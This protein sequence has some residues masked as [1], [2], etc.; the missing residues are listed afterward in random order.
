[1]GRESAS[2][3][4]IA[5][6]QTFVRIVEAGSLS[7][8]AVQLH[9]TQP[10]ISRRL[11]A[12]EHFFGVRLLQRSTHEMKLTK[13]GERCYD[14]A[15]ALLEGWAAF[16][17]DVRGTKDE[18]EGLLRVV[19]PHALGQVRLCAPM[20]RYLREH[21]KVSIEWLLRDEFHD[22]IGAGVD[23]A[24]Q[25]GELR[26]AS[27][28]AWRLS[29]IP[30]IVVASPA[31]LGRRKAPEE[32]SALA[33]LPWLALSTFYRDEVAL[34]HLDGRRQVLPIR[35]RLA[36]DSLYAMRTAALEGTGACIMSSWLVADDLAEGRL[37]HLV[38]DWH[39]QALP[40]WLVYPHAH[41]YP[42]RLRR[43]I[44][45]VRTWA[46]TADAQAAP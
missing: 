6:M 27:L 18:P 12:L 42:A 33:S 40:V 7:A 43:F 19:V 46:R 17:A 45:V 32:P 11:Q 30:R 31:L 36:T 29:E 34:T 13:D 9:T 41:F 35:P 15:K 22:F 10:T 3:D 28:V 25:V 5:L 21:P 4:R 14:R 39:A 44:E 2:T 23:C 38:P 8:A 20:A 26:D 24:I 1:M 37:V 16:E